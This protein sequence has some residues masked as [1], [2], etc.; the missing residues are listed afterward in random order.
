MATWKSIVNELEVRLRESQSSTVTATTYSTLLG[1]FVNTAKVMVEDAWDWHCLRTVLSFTTSGSTATYTITGSN[2]RSR[3][4]T[5][6]R[7]IYD[8]TN[9]AIIVPVPDSYIDQNTYLGT[10]QTGAPVPAVNYR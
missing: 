4:F 8:D 2:E 7:E 10:T 6:L 9:D 1:N 3:F 5:P